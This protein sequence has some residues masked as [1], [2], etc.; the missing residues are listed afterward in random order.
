MHRKPRAAMWL[1]CAI[2]PFALLA[3]LQGQQITAKMP[4]MYFSESS[5][6]GRSF[7][8][9]P[10]VVHF[11]DAYYL[12]FSQARHR[13]NVDPEAIR[14]QGSGGVGSIGIARSTDR[15]HWTLV[16][17]VQPTQPA[18]ALGIG[19]PGARVIRGE[20]H[21][22]YQTG[23]T[24][25][26]DAI[27]HAVSSDGVHFTKDASNPVYHP[28]QMKW[29]VGRAIDAEVFVHGAELWMYF[30][31]RD[32][33]FKRQLVGMAKAPLLSDF[34]R[35]TWHDVSIEQPIL[36]P[37]LPWEMTCIEAPTLAEHNGLLYLFYAGAYN[38]SPQQIGVATSKDGVHWT[39]L[40]EKPLLANGAPGTWNATESG[41]PGILQDDDGQ[42]YLYY[43]GSADKGKTYFLS[44]L[45]VNWD[46]ETPVL[47]EPK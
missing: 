7:A 40:S 15:V 16:G 33:S 36:S 32:P 23:A 47:V 4:A 18:E 13:T 9:D 25:P 38:N 45:K 34:S 2:L 3:R 22:F 43:Q 46:G 26:T 1:L 30:A 24:Q 39:R 42:T 44:M 41:H 12:Y 20:V 17:E 5:K 6:L 11:K 8:K 29:S 21:L 31:T 14:A 35:G 37:D 28:T 27:C 10:S 19:A